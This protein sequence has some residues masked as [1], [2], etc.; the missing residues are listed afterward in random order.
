M[1]TVTGTRFWKHGANKTIQLL[2]Y[3]EARELVSLP[4]ER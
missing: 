4:A 2:E 1:V 3:A